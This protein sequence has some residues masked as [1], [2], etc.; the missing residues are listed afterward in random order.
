MQE[1]D[2]HQKIGVDIDGTLINGFMSRLLQQ[3]IKENHST[4]EFHLITFRDNE[5]IKTLWMEFYKVGIEMHWFKS[6]HNLEEDLNKQWLKNCDKVAHIKSNQKKLDRALNHHKIS[7]EDYIKTFDDINHFKAKICLKLGCT[8]LI[9]DMEELVIG[10]CEFHKI[11]FLN[12]KTGK[13]KKF[14]TMEESS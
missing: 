3:Y 14:Y 7:K 10:G 13:H 11:D 9:D 8:I 6:F 12:A 4:K 1:L 5:Q 2:S